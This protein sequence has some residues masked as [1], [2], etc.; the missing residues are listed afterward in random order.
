MLKIIV[1]KWAFIQKYYAII[2]W[3][4]RYVFLC[5]LWQK[6]IFFQKNM[7]NI[8]ENVTNGAKC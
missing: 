4:Q 5:Y 3:L 7:L 1:K 2:I 6:E 8:Q